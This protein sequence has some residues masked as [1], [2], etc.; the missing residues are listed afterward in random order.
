MSMH[1]LPTKPRPFVTLF[2]LG[3]GAGT[4][5]SL[6]KR[7]ADENPGV[8]AACSPSFLAVPSLGSGSSARGALGTSGECLGCTPGRVHSSWEVVYLSSRE[9]P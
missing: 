8:L 5:L 9:L 7:G 2:S 3:D 1:P 4:G 6:S